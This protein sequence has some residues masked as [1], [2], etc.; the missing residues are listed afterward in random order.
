MIRAA[1]IARSADRPITTALLPPSSSVSGT[2]FSAAARITWRAIEV[3][4]VKTRWSNARLENARPTS[5]PPVTTA[6]FASSKATANISFSSAEVAGVASDGLIIARLPAASTPASGDQILPLTPDIA[7][8]WGR[9]SAQIG[10]NGIDL[11]I[12]ATAMEHG[13]TIVTRNVSDF[14]TTGAAL[15]DPF[16]PRSRR[17]R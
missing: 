17:R 16:E 3:A 4:P 2:R 8:R 1:A 14:V 13:L 6:I 7:R 10:N 11:A 9:L 5:G 15:V 12:A